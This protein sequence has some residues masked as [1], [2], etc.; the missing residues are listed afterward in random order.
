MKIGSLDSH[1]FK[2][3]RHLRLYDLLGAH[4]EEGGV[5]FSV[6]APN[7][8]SVALIGDWNLGRGDPMSEEDGIWSIFLPGIKEGARYQFKVETK[9]GAELLKIDPF[10][11][12]A[13]LRP[14][15]GCI[16]S[17][18]KSY[19]WRDQHWMQERTQDNWIHRPFQIYELHLG[20]W[21]RFGAGEFPNYREIAEPLAHYLNQMGFTHVELMP[22][23]EYPLDESWGY[24]VTG[25]FAPTAR[26]GSL[27]DFQYLVD[28]LHLH[29]IGV[30]LDWVPAHF[31]MDEHSLGLFDGTELYEHADPKKGIHPHWLTHIFDFGKAEVTNFLVA[32]ALFWLKEMHVDGLRVDAVASML[33]LDYGRKYGE[34]EPNRHGGH[35]YLE[36][37]DFF[38]FLNDTIHAEVPGAVTIAEESTAFPK[39][40]HPTS[41]GGLGFDFK[42][43]M[44]WMND[45]LGYFSVWFDD[46]KEHLN[47][48]TF[49][50]TY[51]YS[52]RFI[53]PLSH[54]EVVHEKKSLLSKMPGTNS[55]KFAGLRLLLSYQWCQPGKKLLFMGGEFG[56][57]TEW[58]CKEELPW[59]HLELGSSL[60]IQKLVQ[61][62]NALVKEHPALYEEDSSPT[63]FAWA[64]FEDVDNAVLSYFRKAKNET[65]LIIH[66]F[67]MRMHGA[68]PLPTTKPLKLLFSSDKQCYGGEGRE[69]EANGSAPLPPLSTQ[70]FLVT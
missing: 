10:A 3:G 25:Y 52:E 47:K 58:N 36:A 20:S 28:T 53:L 49:G 1:L 61:D 8:K 34:W 27:Q 63:G 48:L 64:S 43:N 38:R 39:I 32:N 4:V 9:E 15:Q 6:W 22:L 45:T 66:N 16:V 56:Q 67:H 54:D 2:E 46:R 55:E 21:K 60:G 29:G 26:Y 57:W 68:Y 23:S 40:T 35:E 18:Y 31:P 70:V 12:Q 11:F 42:W 69:G 51:A 44:G 14:L 5:R 7:A 62:L 33:Y 59:E 19:S 17:S 24:Q 37:I 30:I 41:E 65:L 13:E 50:Q